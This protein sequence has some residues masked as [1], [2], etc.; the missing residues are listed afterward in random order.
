MKFNLDYYEAQFILDLVKRERRKVKETP[1]PG[2]DK[3]IDKL[4]NGRERMMNSK[5]GIESDFKIFP[6]GFSFFN[7]LNE[8]E[9]TKKPTV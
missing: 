2:V 1:F 8:S 5:H 3:L 7:D 6:D 4:A 9:K